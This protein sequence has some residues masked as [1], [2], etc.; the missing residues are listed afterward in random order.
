MTLSRTRILDFFD[1]CLESSLSLVQGLNAS[2]LNDIHAMIHLVKGGN[3]RVL[4][5]GSKLV[6]LTFGG[7]RLIIAL[8]RLWGVR[9]VHRMAKG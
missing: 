6:P 5:S 3:R 1:G 4:R 8:D 9:C 2:L 7:Q